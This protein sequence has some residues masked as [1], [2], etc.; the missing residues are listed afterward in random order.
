PVL[1]DGSTVHISDVMCQAIADAFSS[2]G[3]G[4]EG[5]LQAALE[6][7]QQYPGEIV[8]L[9]LHAQFPDEIVAVR[10]NKPLEIARDDTGAIYLA[11]PTLAFPDR[12]NRPMRMPPLAGA[13]LHR[14]GSL[15]IVPFEREIIPLGDFPSPARIEEALGAA[16]R[17]A[18]QNIHQLC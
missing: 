2:S 7:Y 18:P 8:G 14:D 10:H 16:L 17:Q 13:I 1:S 4:A 5:L 11:T 9:C 3:G 12:V 6:M 15:R